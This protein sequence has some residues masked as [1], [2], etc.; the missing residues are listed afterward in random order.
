MRFRL[1]FGVLACAISVSAPR[2]TAD[3]IEYP[4]D[5]DSAGVVTETISELSLDTNTSEANGPVPT[6]PAPTTSPV[7]N[8]ATLPPF[9]IDPNSLPPIV[10]D[11]DRPC[12]DPAKKWGAY[13]DFKGWRSLRSSKKR[14]CVGYNPATEGGEASAKGLGEQ[15]EKLIDDYGT[16][17]I[18]TTG[19]FVGRRVV[20]LTTLDVFPMDLD[21]TLPGG[22]QRRAM[23]ISRLP[24]QHAI[25]FNRTTMKV[26]GDIM[27]ETLHAF[28]ADQFPLCSSV[29]LALDEGLAQ[30]VEPTRVTDAIKVYVEN[31]HK[32]PW[33]TYAAPG[34]LLQFLDEPAGVENIR[35]FYQMSAIFVNFLTHELG[36]SSAVPVGK[37]FTADRGP[38]K[39]FRFFTALYKSKALCNDPMETEALRDAFDDAS[40]KVY[41][42]SWRDVEKAY[43]DYLDGLRA[44]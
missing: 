4:L 20:E 18:A 36:K 6:E 9:T 10:P 40:L 16:M 41:G 38:E 27:H 14:F 15:L 12:G 29:R 39:L 24:T 8:S 17:F 43:T 23:Y 35:A 2:A 28:L 5:S 33:T 1:A 31:R 19:L 3:Y 44:P 13:A 34:R 37:T 22:A 7:V 21:P 26:V 42:V 11:L 25:F 30:V 32:A